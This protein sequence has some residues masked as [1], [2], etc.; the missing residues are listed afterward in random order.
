QEPWADQIIRELDSYTEISPSGR[1]AHVITKGELP[2][3]RRQIQFDGDH[4]GVGLYDAARG[5][6]LTMTGSRISGDGTIPERTAE[7]QRI[8]ARLFPTEKPKSK[9]DAPINDDD[10]IAR[11]R[12]ANDSGKF[13]RLW[14]GQWQ[15]EYAS[16]SEADLALC[17]KL[18]FWTNCDARRIDSLFR[19]S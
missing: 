18:A 9:A 5:R 19:R 11:A 3:G 15:E 2:D 8:Y 14:D 10:L 12:R 16:Q 1:G 13:C 6:Y 4:H 17:R 7:L